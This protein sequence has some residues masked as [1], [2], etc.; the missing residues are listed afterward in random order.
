[1]TGSMTSVCVFCGSQQGTRPDYARAAGALGHE[2]ARRG[3]RLVYGGG[4]V[5]LMSVVADAALAAGGEVI[6][7][8]P[9]SLQERE[10]GHGGVTTLHVVRSMHQR[11]ALMAE[12]STAF[13]ALPGG[14]G[15]L[16]EL[17]E[18][19][20]WRQLGFHEKPIGVLNVAGF[21]DPLLSFL[22]HA[23]NE[24]F[25]K[26]VHRHRLIVDDDPARLLK[27]L[28]DVPSSERPLPVEK[29]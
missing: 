19:W 17:A 5:G 13:I 10:L 28:G 27:R 26:P 22:D 16:E 9:D 24:G 18:I 11:K 29:T 25:L 6:G 21:F 7:V 1:M 14:L 8:I 20:T 23:M 4:N 15:T 2:I 12:E 3:W